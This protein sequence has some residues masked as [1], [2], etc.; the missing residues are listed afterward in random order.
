MRH[1]KT[2]VTKLLARISRIKTV[3]TF[4]WKK[5]M[6]W[7]SNEN[8]A[9]RFSSLLITC[10]SKCNGLPTNIWPNEASVTQELE[11]LLDDDEDMRD[12]YLARREDQKLAAEE[13]AKAGHKDS[14]EEAEESGGDIFS[15][16]SLPR[17][18]VPASRS[19]AHH[20]R[21]PLHRGKLPQNST[22]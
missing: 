22:R 8:H 21:E 1:S 18:G 15:I 4:P 10:I 17:G 3:R 19:A 16:E 14:E 20:R 9:T 11:D 5:I 13:S 6:I 7:S 2:A 12:L